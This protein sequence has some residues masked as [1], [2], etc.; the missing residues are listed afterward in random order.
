MLLGNPT[1]CLPAVV[2]MVL[3]VPVATDDLDLRKARPR[4]KPS[5]PSEAATRR[6]AASEVVVLMRGSSLRA[7]GATLTNTCLCMVSR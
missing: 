2:L 5:V 1:V 6:R 4:V 3:G 7:E